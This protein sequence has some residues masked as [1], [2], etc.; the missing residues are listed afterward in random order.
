MRNLIQQTVM[1]G[2]NL[3]PLQNA[4]EKKR[5]ASFVDSWHPDIRKADFKSK[6]MESAF[7]FLA[8]KIAVCRSD[9]ARRPF[10]LVGKEKII[11]ASL[12]YFFLPSLA[13]IPGKLATK[14]TRN[15]NAYPR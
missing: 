5:I 9:C 13:A 14:T 7:S 10:G 12:R 11:L 6:K 15:K 1:K 3:H 8:A 4:N 2:E